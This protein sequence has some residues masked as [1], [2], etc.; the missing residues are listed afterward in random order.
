V[1]C[2]FAVTRLTLSTQGIRFHRVF[3]SPRFLPWDRIVSVAVAP[4]REL[5][6]QGWLWPPFPA[7]EMTASLTAREHVRISWQDGYCY[8]PPVEL[9][10]VLAYAATHIPR[11]AT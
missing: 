1:F 11:D 10:A 3:G 2:S 4:R 7:R 5:V 9:E 6:L 8:F